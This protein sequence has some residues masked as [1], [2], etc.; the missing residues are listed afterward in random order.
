MMDG[1]CGLAYFFEQT[2]KVE[3]YIRYSQMKSLEEFN[4]QEAIHAD[5]HRRIGDNGENGGESDRLV[6]LLT[7]E[8]GIIR[9][10]S[11]LAKTLKSKQGSATQLLCY[12][13]FLFT[14][15]GTNT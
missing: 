11:P 8:E 15:G 2:G 7:R 14:E 6:T 5:Q 3:D 1:I 4:S 10:F 9:A 13:R 12:S